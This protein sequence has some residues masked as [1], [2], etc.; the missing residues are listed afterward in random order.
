MTQTLAEYDGGGNLIANYVYGLGLVYKVDT[1]DKPYFYHYNFTGSTVAMTDT[2]GNIINKYAYTPFGRLA[3][4]VESVPNPFRY[5]GKSGV[6]DDKSG[7][8]Y[9]RARYYDPE[10]G[11]FITKDPIGFDGGVNLY[12]YVGENPINFIDPSGLAN[13]LDAIWE[14][15]K[16]FGAP[17]VGGTD[18]LTLI[19]PVTHK[20][21]T[22]MDIGLADQ[23]I[24]NMVIEGKITTQEGEQLL[25]LLYQKDFVGLRIKWNEIRKAHGLPCEP[26]NRGTLSPFF[27]SKGL[28]Y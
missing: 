12:G 26:E 20:N 13:V 1:S 2:N 25:N 23:G 5:V 15:I 18:L 9:M 8:F 28:R 27:E 16:S 3:G 21:I 10:V 4:S 6:M 17:H 11:R 7:L 22:T 14:F 19:D 24:Q